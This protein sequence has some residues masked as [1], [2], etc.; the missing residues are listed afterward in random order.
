MSAW[1]CACELLCTF[2]ARTA[3]NPMFLGGASRSMLQEHSNCL[4]SL[5]RLRSP[6]LNQCFFSS[7]FYQNAF[8]STAVL[9]RYYAGQKTSA[10]SP[11]PQ[12]A[13]PHSIVTTK[14]RYIVHFSSAVTSS[15]SS[16][17]QHCPWVADFPEIWHI[18]ILYSV[19]H[20]DS[21]SGYSYFRTPPFDQRMPDLLYWAI[22][23]LFSKTMLISTFLPK[24]YFHLF[25]PATPAQRLTD[26]PY[27][28]SSYGF[29]LF[30]LELICS[31]HRSE[32]RPAHHYS[33]HLITWMYEGF[34]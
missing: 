15:T 11:Q 28:L 7:C 4:S 22:E 20:T 33:S 14:C 12:D 1:R 34:S 5:L 8:T 10:P 18:L 25:L 29:M 17:L 21:Q 19:T 30:T 27:N 26:N 31:L 23:L 13:I 16:L 6:P 3:L 24:S 2:H 9:L 32:N